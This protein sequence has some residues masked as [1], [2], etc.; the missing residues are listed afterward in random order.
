MK[1]TRRKKLKFQIELEKFLQASG[2][3]EA[4]YLMGVNQLPHQCWITGWKQSEVQPRVK[5]KHG[6]ARAG[7]IHPQFLQQLLMKET[8]ARPFLAI[9]SLSSTDSRQIFPSTY[10]SASI[11]LGGFLYARDDIQLVFLNSF[12]LPPGTL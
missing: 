3:V 4:P 8:S 11:L 12:I 10:S 6:S 2:D 7:I 1:R 5:H 9:P